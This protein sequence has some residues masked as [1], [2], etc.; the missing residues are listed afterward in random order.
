MKCILF[1]LLIYTISLYALDFNHKLY[2]K[3]NY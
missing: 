3:A 1:I 2:N